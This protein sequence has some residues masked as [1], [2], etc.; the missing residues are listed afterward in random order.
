MLNNI[1]HIES[2]EDFQ[3]VLG[4]SRP[5]AVIFYGKS[6]EASQSAGPMLEDLAIEYQG[7][8]EFWRV[9]VEEQETLQRRYE[10]KDT[11][12]VTWDA[13]PGKLYTLV[14]TD[15]DAPSRAL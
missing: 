4:L 14:L 9:D 3:A 12:T 1:R 8:I 5:A 15:P 10:I 6:C 13:E 11:P 7:D 2:L